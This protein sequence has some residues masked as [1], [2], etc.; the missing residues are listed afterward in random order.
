MLNFHYMIPKLFVRLREH[1]LFSK[2]S[3][4]KER[5]SGYTHTY[6]DNRDVDLVNTVHLS[7]Q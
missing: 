6:T 4:G 2:F 3:D 7:F 5:A 1:A